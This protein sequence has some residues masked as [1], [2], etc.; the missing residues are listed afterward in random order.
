MNS[1]TIRFVIDTNVLF[2]GLTKKGSASS[3]LID[4]WY[5]ELFQAYVTT[6]LAYE[7][8]DVLSRKL[9]I[10]RWDQLQPAL[11]KLLRLSKEVNV[12]YSWRPISPDIGDDH[13]VDCAMNAGA[14]VVTWNQKDFRSA[15][16]TLGLPI[17]T[18]VGAVALLIEE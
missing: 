4:A 15:N 17:L 13:V 11:G 7:Y 3:F 9:P 16:E 14:Y 1:S 10:R 6:T 18:P 12:H 2:E 8:A 5:A